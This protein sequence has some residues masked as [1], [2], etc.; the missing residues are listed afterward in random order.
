LVELLAAVGIG[1]AVALA[2]AGLSWGVVRLAEGQSGRERVWRA[3]TA[4]LRMAQDLACA[5]APPAKGGEAVFSA[6]RPEEGGGEEGKIE[7]WRPEDRAAW[8][9]TYG[10]RRVVWEW[11]KSGK[12]RRVLTREERPSSGPG[13]NAPLREVLLEGD[14]SMSASFRAA[15]GRPEEAGGSPAGAPALG[16]WMEGTWPLAVGGGGADS[17]EGEKKNPLPGWVRLEWEGG[18]ERRVVESVVQAAHFVPSMRG[19]VVVREEERVRETPPT[20]PGAPGAPPPPGKEA[21]ED[22]GEAPEEEF[23]MGMSEE[24]FEEGWLGD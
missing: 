18:G 11:K 17:G 22:G 10:V 20:P 9:E 13:T 21:M 8:S 23:G 14:F 7:F 24:E 2:L 5:Y 16:D 6:E 15:P 12:G 4:L 1:A 19:G 3:E